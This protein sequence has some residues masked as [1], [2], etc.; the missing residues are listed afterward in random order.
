MNVVILFLLALAISEFTVISGQ[1]QEINENFGM[2]EKSYM[3]ISE[4]QRITYDV[5]TLIL[6]NEGKLINAQ[7]YL[8]PKVPDIK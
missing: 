6:I 7:R 1:F 2:I 8:S 5:R 4:I 3:R